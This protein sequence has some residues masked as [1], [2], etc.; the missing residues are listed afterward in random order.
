MDL[1]ERHESAHHSTITPLA[2]KLLGNR[3]TTYLQRHGVIDRPGRV[4]LRQV[5]SFII[6]LQERATKLG[7]RKKNQDTAYTNKFTSEYLH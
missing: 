7:Q 3:S 2:Q 5:E 4:F 1:P 6:S